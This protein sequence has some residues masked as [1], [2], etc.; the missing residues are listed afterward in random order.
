MAISK[1][2]IVHIECNVNT[3]K[4]MLFTYGITNTQNLVPVCFTKNILNIHEGELQ[5]TSVF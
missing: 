2:T 4:Q 3:L 5:W 1:W